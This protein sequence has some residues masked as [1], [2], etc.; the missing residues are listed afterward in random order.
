MKVYIAR[1]QNNW[2]ASLDRDDAI[3]RLVARTRSFEG[4]QVVSTTGDWQV[5]SM[6]GCV[7]SDEE[8]V[9]ETLQLGDLQEIVSYGLGRVDAVLSAMEE[10]TGKNYQVAR[11]SIERAE[12]FVDN[13]E[14]WEAPEWKQVLIGKNPSESSTG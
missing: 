2:T 4:V 6:D 7:S 5:S 8:I 1:G 3:L 14:D 12:E 11:R 13:V 10:S 9:E